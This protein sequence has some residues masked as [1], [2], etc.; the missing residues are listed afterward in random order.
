MRVRVRNHVN[1]LSPAFSVLRGRRPDIPRGM[2]V[3]VEVGCAD[4]QFLFERAAR[5]PDRFYVGLEIREELVDA[6][7]RRAT[8]EGV[9]VC[10]VFCNANEHLR[11]LFDPESI[12]RIYINFPDPWFKRRHRKRRMVDAGLARDC[13]RALAGGGEL[14]VQTDV[15]D[16]ALDAL[17]AFDGVLDNR[18]GEWSF[19]KQGN[20]FGAT[21]WRERQCAAR[22]RPV[23]RLLFDKP[24]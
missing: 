15:W 22:G 24:A 3:E 16:V 5:C 23:W 1:P 11:E 6:V 14:F 19:W 10:A 8:D 17:A 18:A 13:A 2:P 20:P 7:N 12:S 4:A 9:P 21:S